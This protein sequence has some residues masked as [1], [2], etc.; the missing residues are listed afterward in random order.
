MYIDADFGRPRPHFSDFVEVLVNLCAG[1]Y[2]FFVFLSLFFRT[3]LAGVSR[4]YLHPGSLKSSQTVLVNYHHGME[5]S[6]VWGQGRTSSSDGQRFGIQGNSMQASFYPRYFGYYDRAITVLTHVSDQFSVFGTQVISCGTREALYVLDA[7]LENDTDL[8][9]EEH[10]TDTHGYTEQLCGL[11]HMLG[12][13]F[14]PRIANLASCQLYRMDRTQSYGD[15]DA[16]LRQPVDLSLIGEQ[17]DPM[18]RVVASLRNRTAPAN[19]VVQRLVA[20]RPSD[21]LAKAFREL[22]R[23]TKTIYILRY[24]HEP[25]LRKRIQLQL[26]RGE[27]RHSLAKRLFFAN[28]G[29]F[30]ESDLESIMN[31]ASCL[32]LLSNAVLVWNTKNLADI[33]DRI[34]ASGEDVSDAE[35]AQISPLACKHIIPNG[36]YSFR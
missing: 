27:A 19:V 30:R 1:L 31:K 2:M 7:L 6:G 11:F 23:L 10:M 8:N 25:E 21:R 34:R 33:V 17:W 15:L 28:Q 36:T 18:V 32:S 16:I 4:G 22:G 29:E 20:S 3:L 12:L 35:L 14:M 5:A 24:L 13:A 9:I 26:N